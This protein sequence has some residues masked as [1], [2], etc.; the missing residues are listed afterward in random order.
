MGCGS[1]SAG[2]PSGADGYN[3]RARWNDDKE[4]IGET[5]QQRKRLDKKSGKA[6]TNVAEKEKPETDFFEVM[7]AGQ[8]E[9]FM[10]VRP[11][12]GAIVE[13]TNHNP[14]DPSAPDVRFELEYVYGY[15]CADS[16]QNLF[17]N[18]SNQAVYMTAALGVILDPSSN[19]QKFFGGGQVDNT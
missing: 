12:E 6:G 5:N 11:Y 10:A 1:S 18:N 14:V 9:Q 4:F 8:G 19:T 2:D 7:E 16:R 15:R 13:P 17:F 3:E